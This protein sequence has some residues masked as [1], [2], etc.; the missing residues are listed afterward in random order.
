MRIE[1][2]AF[3]AM[4]THTL[5]EINERLESLKAWAGEQRPDIES[6]A[7]PPAGVA[8]FHADK[9]T[10][11]PLARTAGTEAGVPAGLDRAP[12]GKA[13]MKI[14]SSALQ[15]MVTHVLSEANERI[16]SLKAW[17]GE[18][19]PDFEGAAATRIDTARLFADKAAISPEAR[20]KEAEAAAA[21]GEEG[22]AIA[23]PKLRMLIALIERIT[24]QR[25]RIFDPSKFERGAAEA[26]AAGEAVKHAAAPPARQGWGVEY[27]L[28][29]THTEVESTV[30][31]ASGVVRTADGKEIRFQVD[32]VMARE[33]TERREV[34]IRLGD[35][36][37]KDPLVLNFNG[38]A[39]ELGETVVQ[40]DL[41]SDGQDDAM[42]M[43]KPGS[44]FLF[45]DR[46]GDSRPMNGTEMF[47]ART[48]NGFQ[49]LKQLDEDGNGFVDEG[50]S[51]YSF[52]S[53]WSADEE[54]EEQVQT[55]EEAG[56]GAISVDGIAT[57]FALK[58]AGNRTLG[59]VRATSIYLTESGGVGTVQQVDIG[60]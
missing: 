2:S 40:F 32:L 36:R 39:A 22:E 52:L 10:I 35:A 17:T 13:E 14:E 56:V 53:L 42:R 24:G 18:R 5:A 44:A 12:Q 30:F 6:T 51:A 29:E 57:P 41:D 55:L 47:G 20:T 7:I 37:L 21:T 48:G 23:D 1:S 25:V 28:K 59:Q 58:D 15:A 27:D 50:D 8:R 49:E 34:A 45:I 33:F 31:S 4:A 9:A 3:Q 43:L 16:E 11:S 54:G 26:R 38:K 60:I 46:D 19:R